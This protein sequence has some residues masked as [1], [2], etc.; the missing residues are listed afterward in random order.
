MNKENHKNVCRRMLF[1]PGPLD[2][3]IDKISF[4]PDLATEGLRVAS[5]GHG[6]TIN[7]LHLPQDPCLAI[8]ARSRCL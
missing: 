6:G 8:M 4:D 5:T 7:V 1:L 3:S 2:G